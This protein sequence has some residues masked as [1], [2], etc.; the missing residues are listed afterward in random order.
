M[1]SLVSNGQETV[2]KSVA[3]MRRRR[4]VVLIS[5][6]IA[7]MFMTVVGASVGALNLSFGPTLAILVQPLGLDL[8]WP[9]DEGSSSILWGIRMP[10]VILG[11]LVGAVLSVSGAMMQGLFRNPLAEP[12]L[13]GVSSGAALAAA[14]VIVLGGRFIATLPDGLR[15]FVLPLAAFTGGAISTY[16][17]YRVSLQSGRLSVSTMLLAGIA[18]NAIGF[19]MLGMLQYV[20]DDNELRGLTFWMLGSLGGATWESLAVVAPL[21]MLPLI[22]CYWL[23]RPLNCF[24]LGEVEAMHLGV[25]VQRV[26]RIAVLLV[27]LGVGATV[28][29]SGMIAFLGLVVPHLIRLAVSPDHRIVLPGSALLGAV[30]LVAADAF[31][32]VVVM[33]SELPVGIVTTLF[34]APFFLVLLF[35]ARRMNIQP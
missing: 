35:K 6:A 32:R 13:I 14:V 25:P 1:N 16:L 20:A 12:G 24:L 30:L 28:A 2:F 27:A 5:L 26:N 31:A 4:R 18:F 22:G 34:G 33:P 8:P 3:R 9:S 19:A 11:I 10:R 29:V 15:L 17:V 23:A 21:L 7:L